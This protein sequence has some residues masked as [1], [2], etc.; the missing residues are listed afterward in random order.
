MQ[1]VLL[2]DNQGATY[3][4][5]LSSKAIEMFRT[6]YGIHLPIP[7]VYIDEVVTRDSPLLINIVEKLGD[8]TFRD[9]D[10]KWKVVEVPD[11]MKWAIAFRD[12]GDEILYDK[13]TAIEPN[14][15]ES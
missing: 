1:K 7:E 10:T 4:L 12:N 8:D 9:M 5:P 2:L 11:D 6:E 13:R 3:G 15:R 14:F